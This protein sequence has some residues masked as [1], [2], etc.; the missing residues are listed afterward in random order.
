MR[1]TSAADPRLFEATTSIA[2]EWIEQNALDDFPGGVVTQGTIVR[3]DH[4]ILQTHGQWFEPVR[5]DVGEGRPPRH[6][7]AD[8]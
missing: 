3:A 6:R 2:S 1:K 8:R 4:P 5:S 7:L